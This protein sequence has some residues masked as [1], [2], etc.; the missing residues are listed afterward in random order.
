[1]YFKNNLKY[2]E[3]I[4]LKKGYVFFLECFCYIYLKEFFYVDF[5]ECDWNY[6]VFKFNFIMYIGEGFGDVVKI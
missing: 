5:F 6:N 2:N 3:N 1:M 4:Y